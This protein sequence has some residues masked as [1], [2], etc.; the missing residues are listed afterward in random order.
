MPTRRYAGLKIVDFEGAGAVHAAEFKGL[1]SVRRDWSPLSSKLGIEVAH[2]LLSDKSAEDVAWSIH[3]RLS[4]ARR[5]PC[6]IAGRDK[7]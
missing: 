6:S 2:M 1:D 7:Y 4:Q 5:R 3:D